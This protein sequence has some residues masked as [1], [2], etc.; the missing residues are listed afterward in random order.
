M[1]AAVAFL[2]EAAPWLFAPQLGTCLV[3]SA[4]L[5][6]A[7]AARGIAGPDPADVDLAWALDTAAGETLLKEHGVFVA[8]TEGNLDRGTLAMK[9]G[10]RRLEITTFRGADVHAPL[11]RR[12]ADDL[13]ERDMTIG[14][15]AL[16]LA[17][18]TWHDPEGGLEDWCGRR[19]RA[20]GSARDRVREHPVR[21]L[22]YYRKAHELGFAIDGGIRKLDLDPRLLLE[23]P[24]EAVAGE[25]R[26][27]L[28]KC[29][30]PGRCLLEMHEAGILATLSP[31][32]ALQFDGRPAGPQRYH[33][34]ISQ[35][36]HLILALEWAFAHTRELD[37]RDALAVRTA[38]LCHDFGKGL[39]PNHELPSHYGHDRSGLK[40]IDAFLGRW[41]GL[42][43]P[44]TRT[45]AR[46]VCAV[47]L[48][49]HRF[50]DLKPGTLATLYD[51]WLRGGDFATELFALAIAADAAGR[52]GHEHEGDEAYRRVVA[53]IT[54]LRQAC[55]SVDAAALRAQHADDLPAFRAALHEARARALRAHPRPITSPAS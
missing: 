27:I 55:A 30:S 28:R 14:A 32:L 34:E 5:A 3:G 18:G 7:C 6:A 44:R 53:E 24:S 38:V 48:L 39:T 25:L 45:L 16:Q 42:A 52:L 51:E 47:H 11:S 19:V 35:S 8:T 36:L 2:R 26:A 29:A 9:L 23:L 50:D 22:R 15:I 12:I 21:W 1:S 13:A 33:P 10:G 31:E 54:W 41:P 46:Q 4:A 37:E 20:V 49:V 17:D 40:P 43:D